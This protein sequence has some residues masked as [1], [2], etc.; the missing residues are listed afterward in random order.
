MG[1]REIRF[2]EMISFRLPGEIADKWRKS[3]EAAEMSLTDFIKS[4]VKVDGV[5][6]FV[7]TRKTP[8]RKVSFIE[9]DPELI[10]Q[11]ARIGN[12]LNQIAKWC[13]QS[14]GTADARE[15][16][17]HLVSIEQLVAKLAG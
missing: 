9:A 5:E 2:D 14:K 12:N 11:I 1:K 4:Q 8:A 16:I 17:G 15:I 7:P 10:Q 13:N 6:P 3:A